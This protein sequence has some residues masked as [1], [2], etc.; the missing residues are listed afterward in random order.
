MNLAI[1]MNR[2][3]IIIKTIF[4]ITREIFSNFLVKK[5]YWIPVDVPLKNMEPLCNY[6]LSH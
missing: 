3:I 6:L 4:M 1:I 2:I 5:L